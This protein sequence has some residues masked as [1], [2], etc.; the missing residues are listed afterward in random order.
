MAVVEVTTK[1]T[2]IASSLD[3]AWTFALNRAERIGDAPSIH[4]TPLWDYETNPNGDLCFEVAV[5]GRSKED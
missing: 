2:T 3:E 5:Q 4:I 1:H